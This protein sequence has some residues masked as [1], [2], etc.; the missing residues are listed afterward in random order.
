MKYII[1]ILSVLFN[2]ACTSIANSTDEVNNEKEPKPLMMEITNSDELNQALLLATENKDY[3]LLVTSGRNMNIPG[4][5]SSDYKAAIA[6]CGK[7]YSPTTGDVITSEEQ[8]EA[9][10]KVISY[11]RQYNEK[12]LMICQENK[13]QLTEK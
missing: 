6:L 4:V 2:T 1:L 10:K 5:E 13:Q 12:M 7:K 9:R 8:R 11:M 3:R